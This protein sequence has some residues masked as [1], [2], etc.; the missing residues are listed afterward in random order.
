MVQRIWTRTLP[1]PGLH[2][3]PLLSGVQALLLCRFPLHHPPCSPHCSSSSPSLWISS[4]Y[5]EEGHKKPYNLQEYQSIHITVRL[6]SPYFHTLMHIPI[7]IK[8]FITPEFLPEPVASLCVSEGFGASA[9]F[10][11]ER[12][13]Y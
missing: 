2:L 5:S 4:F 12:P 6:F 3:F 10:G 13:S 1:P 9:G 11:A 7:I 8:S